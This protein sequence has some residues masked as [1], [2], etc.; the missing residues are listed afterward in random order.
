MSRNGLFFVCVCALLT[1]TPNIVVAQRGGG[2][3]PGTPMGPRPLDTITRPG[4]IQDAGTWGYWTF[5]M[6]EADRAGALLL[7][8]VAIEGE[9]LPWVPILVTVDCN[10]STVYTTQSDSKGN[11]VVTPARI[12]GELSQLQDMRRQMQTHY[13]G[14]VLEGFLTGF[15]S[16]KV[17][18]TERNLRDDP[19]VGTV[20][21]SRDSNARGT[22]M[23][24]TSETAPESAKKY[25]ASAG[26]D[27]FAQKPEHAQKDLE[28]AVRAYPGFADAWYQLGLIQLQSSP[29]DAKACFDRAVAADPKFVLPFEQ[30]T[31]LAAQNGDWQ[32]VLDN[33]SHFL[34]LDPAGSMRV[35]Y[36]SALANYQLGHLVSAED[37]GKKLM[38]ADPLHN[39][40]NGE[41][42]L[43]AILAR[44]A[45]YN[46]AIS[47]LRNCLTYV[48]AGPDADMLKQEIAQL[49]RRVSA[50][51]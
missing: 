35:W 15:R 22:A 31:A 10:D 27:M 23:S 29:R 44:K 26:Q 30:L 28:K 25:W 46:G 17:A 38:A 1:V 9:T 8:K 18:I 4:S 19:N 45:D 20:M 33:V 24:A 36:F 42:L 51:K 41:Q 50:A 32:A 43:A 3:P 39:I 21:L 48:P 40:Q 16:A 2:P 49:E 6:T 14:C 13:E 47:H 5:N 37:S 7:G 11:F 34:E 12:P